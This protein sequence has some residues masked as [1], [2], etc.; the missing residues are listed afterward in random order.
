MNKKHLLTT[1]MAMGCLAGA[2]TLNS[3]KDESATP[4]ATSTTTANVTQAA[5]AYPALAHMPATADTYATI[6]LSAA[7][8]LVAKTG[9]P[10]PPEVQEACKEIESLAVGTSSANA[11]ILSDLQPILAESIKLGFSMEVMK[12][13]SVALSPEMMQ[14]AITSLSAKS[15][16]EIAMNAINSL[17]AS[18]AQ[19]KPVYTIAKL[20]SEQSTVLQQIKQVSQQQE[21]SGIPGLDAWSQDGWSGVCLDI[22]NIPQEALA[23]IPPPVIEKLE[24]SKFYLVYRVE[25]DSL[26]TALATNPA[27]LSY[28][29]T[30][31]QSVLATDAAA[32]LEVAT[33][34]QPLLAANIGTDVVNAINNLSKTTIKT[35][36]AVLTD[37]FNAVAQERPNLAG[38]MQKA[39]TGVQDIVT[40]LLKLA[41]KQKK[42]LSLVLWHDGDLHLQ[43]DCDACGIEFTPGTVNT[44]APENALVHAYGSSVSNLPV[45][46]LDKMVKG[47]FSVGKGLAATMESAPQQELMNDIMGAE[48]AYSMVPA[49]TFPLL[50]MYDSLGNG[51][52]CTVTKTPEQPKGCVVAE[53]NLADRTAL[54]K[55]WTET[56]QIAQN[57]AAFAGPQAVEALKQQLEAFTTATDGQ[58]TVYTWAP[59]A[60]ML[61][62][63]PG[64]AITD[65]KVVLGT[66]PAAN[67][68]A[69]NTTYT[70]TYSGICLT[71]DLKQ[72]PK[73]E[74]LLPMVEG[75]TFSITTQDGKL[76][77]RLDLITPILK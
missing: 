66:D 3:C 25:G 58:A 48:L 59:G 42:P 14:L 28:A 53:F 43:I 51:W 5:K 69:A 54:E 71:V 21:V 24:G 18:L 52:S 34:H 44:Q 75:A 13:L 11:R 2:L 70:T 12:N 68:K 47:A 10:I 27:D 67:A 29:E 72:V 7:L 39:T 60:E 50:N 74:K 65:S 36:A 15:E 22:A 31:A 41:P 61:G 57:I 45:P 38:E 49:F 8:Q 6:N 20:T 64:C 17:T 30:P 37:F 63:T 19:L 56:T 4:A 76:N 55:A 62:I 23:E 77:T 33:A 46:Y 1:A 32:S 73:C 9:T 26:I 16:E 35:P 40:E